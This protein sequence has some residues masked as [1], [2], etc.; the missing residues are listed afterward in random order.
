MGTLGMGTFC[1]FME[2]LLIGST[3]V[4]WILKYTS[5]DHRSATKSFTIQNSVAILD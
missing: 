3:Y 4:G 1:T 2:L 5:T